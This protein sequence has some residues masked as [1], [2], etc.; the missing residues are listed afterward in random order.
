VKGV[1]TESVRSPGTMATAR[2]WAVLGC[3]SACTILVI[4][5]VASINLAVPQLAASGL[6]PTSAQLS[7]IV[8]AYVVFFACLVIPAGAAGDRYGRKGVLL[9]GL[10]VLATGAVVIAQ[11]RWSRG[12]RPSTSN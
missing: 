2:P 6:H 3:V 5:F 11:L 4:G 10:A 1:T 9:C 12:R 7:W 8:D